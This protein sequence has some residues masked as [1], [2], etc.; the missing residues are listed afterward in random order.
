[1][2]L[3]VHRRHNPLLV[4]R[5]GL[6]DG[7]AGEGT[8]RSARVDGDGTTHS[9]PEERRHVSVRSRHTHEFPSGQTCGTVAGYMEYLPVKAD[10]TVSWE[11]SPSDVTSRYSIGTVADDWSQTRLQALDT[12]F[13]IV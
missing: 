12:P 2:L 9:H 5:E 3:P 1:M 7:G 6:K 8:L 13:K 11:P 10:G 4:A